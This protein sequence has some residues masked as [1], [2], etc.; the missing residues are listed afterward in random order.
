MFG[1]DEAGLSGTRS[2]QLQ[3]LDQCRDLRN[4]QRHGSI[5]VSFDPSEIEENF[6]PLV[7]PC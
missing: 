2:H 6:D 7:D 1:S 5:L 3:H 4:P